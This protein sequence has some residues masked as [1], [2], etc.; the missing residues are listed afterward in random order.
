[1]HI[2][3]WRKKNAKKKGFRNNLNLEDYKTAQ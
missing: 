2:K 3:N 1:M